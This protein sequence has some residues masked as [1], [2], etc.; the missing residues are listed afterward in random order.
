[1]LFCVIVLFLPV[2]KTLRIWPMLPADTAYR[3]DQ[4]ACILRSVITTLYILRRV[5]T[6]IY[7]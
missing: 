2:Y 4:S 6:I 7:R 3:D 5:T 1:M